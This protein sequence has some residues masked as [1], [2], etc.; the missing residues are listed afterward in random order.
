MA[1]YHGDCKRGGG[2]RNPPPSEA[3]NTGLGLA[4]GPSPLC[5]VGR[6][7]HAHPSLWPTLCVQDCSPSPTLFFP[8][9]SF[10]TPSPP[11]LQYP[12]LSSMPSNLRATFTPWPS[13]SQRAARV[14]WSHILMSCLSTGILTFFLPQIL[15][16]FS[17]LLS[18]MCGR[19]VQQLFFGSLRAVEVEV[20]LQI[21]LNTESDPLTE[22]LR[23]H[24]VLCHRV[25]S[26]IHHFQR[27]D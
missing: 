21:F 25:T 15:A 13:T 17:L 3:L 1:C 20:R 10:S 23:P 5:H 9:A 8:I 12:P 14:F 4:R 6:W 11:P 24:V 22:T 26:S 18:L 27:R 19:L 2:Q 16:N 7:H